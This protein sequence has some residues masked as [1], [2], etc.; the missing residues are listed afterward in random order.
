MV[1]RR[2]VDIAADAPFATAPVVTA[3]RRGGAIATRTCRRAVLRAVTRPTS[4]ARNGRCTRT[5]GWLLAGA[6]AACAGYDR[7]RHTQRADEEGFLSHCA[8]PNLREASE[9]VKVKVDVDVDGLRPG[10]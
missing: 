5:C 10:R 3:R 1:Q 6:R 4:H 2:R 7:G 8:L 9:S